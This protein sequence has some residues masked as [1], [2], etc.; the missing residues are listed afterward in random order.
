M[1]KTKENVAIEAAPEV[2]A[3]GTNIV[4][5]TDANGIVST[6]D[7]GKKGLIQK[8]VVI[9]AEGI[10]VSLFLVTGISK[11]FTFLKSNALFDLMA[12]R[13]VI[14]FIGNS[15]AGVYQDKDGTHPEDFNLGI[16]QAV[17]ALIAGVIPT[18]E[19]ADKAARG[20]GDL[21]RAYVELRSE[22]V[23][24]KGNPR[25]SAEDITYE[26]VKTLIITSDEA[27]NKG[28][29]AQKAVKAKIEGYKLERQSAR[30]AAANVGLVEA[31]LI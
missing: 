18:R 16:E 6:R 5:F 26:A 19:R 30:T 15:I 8:D 29:L 12:A 25:F 14:E 27:T 20:L 7:F 4:S 28:R 24:A 21:I 10:H 31:D 11:S 13:G 2:I 3:A 9:D 22:A 17:A 1:M 23:D